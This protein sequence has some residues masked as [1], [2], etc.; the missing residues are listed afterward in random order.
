MKIVNTA[1][2][3]SSKLEY[4]FRSLLS[5]VEVLSYKLQLSHETADGGR[6]KYRRAYI[7]LLKQVVVE[8]LSFVVSF[9]LTYLTNLSVPLA[10]QRRLIRLSNK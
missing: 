3:G 6:R 9:C 8:T 10:I 4:P 1:F 2:I 5:V 7:L